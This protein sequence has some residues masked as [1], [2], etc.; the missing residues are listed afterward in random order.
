MKLITQK[1]NGLTLTSAE[2]GAIVEQVRGIYG[3][4]AEM[5]EH[6]TQANIC[7][8]NVSDTPTLARMLIAYG[9]EC[10]TQIFRLHLAGTLVRIGETKVDYEVVTS[11][12]EAMADTMEL[13]TRVLEF[14]RVLGFFPALERGEFNLYGCTHLQIM[15]AFHDYCDNAYH[16]QTLAREAREKAER[17]EADAK[18]RA[19]S[20]TWEQ[21]KQMRGITEENPLNAF[22]GGF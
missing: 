7:K 14:Q 18:H 4:N 11:V 21:Y 2:Q 19:E 10:I 6:F 5:L 8:Q 22:K 12:A 15:R 13:T 17:E 1:Q 3:S 20:V 16:T 9:R